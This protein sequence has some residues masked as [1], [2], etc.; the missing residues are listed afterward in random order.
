MKKYEYIV[1]TFRYG[2]KQYKVYG[3]TLEEA[4]EKRLEL[5]S[6]LQNEELKKSTITVEAWTETAL[7][8]YKPNVSSDYMYQM[9]GRIDK[10]IIPAI[11]K[12]QI[13]DV[14]PLQCQQILNA[15]AGRSSSHISKLSQELFFIFD[16]AR[17]NSLIRTNPAAD[18][19]PPAG[20]KGTRRSITVEERRHF[21]AVTESDP[22][23][24]IFRLMLFCGLRS[25]EA[26]KLTYEDITVLDGVQFF[27]V[28][29]TK[30]KAADRLVPIPK[31]I[32]LRKGCGIIALDP[33]GRPYTKNSYRCA[34]DRLRR[35]MN[36]SMGAQMN[37]HRHLI[38]PLPLAEDF[39]PYY[40]RHTYCVDL[41]KK[42]VD[43]R[44]AKSLMGHA[45][46]RVTAD[47]YDHADEES[48]VLAAR[49]MGLM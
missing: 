32:T 43:L 11:G 16:T 26:M 39:V 4:L 23:Y 20:S 14:T 7:D 27:H 9:R 46:I 28:R 10:H 6:R 37:S 30:T 31:E 18:I 41:K 24:M 33:E 35:D 2:G 34:S 38:P 25:S 40:L 47:I 12:M 5:K 17:K 48:A 8:A 13:Q 36:L 22:Q 44:L 45:D 15:Q 49:Q 29:G 42:G 19:V 21:L 1:K 3:K